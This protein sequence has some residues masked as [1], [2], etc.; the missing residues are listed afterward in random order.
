M[1]SGILFYDLIHSKVNVN[2][3]IHSFKY[4]YYNKFHTNLVVFEQMKQKHFQSFLYDLPL[5]EIEKETIL[6]QMKI[7]HFNLC[8]NNFFCWAGV[9]AFKIVFRLFAA[10]LT[11][12]LKFIYC[13]NLS[14]IAQLSGKKQLR[15]F[16][17]KSKYSTI[18][19]HS[20][21]RNIQ[22]KYTI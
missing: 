12:L 13:I 6:C 7:S 11:E 18:A 17:P 14:L 9:D 20:K 8:L 10:A 1:R 22:K 5:Q 19:L 4:I 16:P 2:L 3:C 21:P 15:L